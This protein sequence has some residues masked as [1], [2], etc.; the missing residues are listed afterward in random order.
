M[1]EGPDHGITIKQA[2]ILLPNGVV[3]TME[4]PNRHHNII[5]AL[6]AAGVHKPVRGDQGFMDSNGDFCNRAL[7]RCLAVES[8][9]ATETHHPRELFSED[10]W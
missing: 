3:C 4:R 5:Q 9:Q 2:A 1:S 10:L 7:A 6:A 8:G